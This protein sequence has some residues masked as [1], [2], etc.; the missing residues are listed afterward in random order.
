[1]YQYTNTYMKKP[2]LY[3]GII[4]IIILIIITLNYISRNIHFIGTL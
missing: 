4:L 1:M 3:I 2:V